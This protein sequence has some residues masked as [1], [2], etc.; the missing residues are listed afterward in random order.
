[1]PRGQGIAGGKHIAEI[2][3]AQKSFARIR[4]FSHAAHL[5]II[6]SWL[7]HR[8]EVGQ[9]LFG[10]DAEVAGPTVFDREFCRDDVTLKQF[11][12]AAQTNEEIDAGM[13]ILVNNVVFLD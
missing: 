1:M 10:L 2:P 4:S 9:Y 7:K 6:Y 8:D 5:R 12:G 13:P 11:P 3:A